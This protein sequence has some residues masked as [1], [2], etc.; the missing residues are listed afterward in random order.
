MSMARV[1]FRR[2]VIEVWYKLLNAGCRVPLVAGSGK[3]SNAQALG[4]RR[5]YARMDAFSYRNWIDAVR[6]GRVFVT[7]GP[8]VT[9]TVEGKG[10]GETVAVPASQPTIHVKV[11]AKSQTP[12]ERLELVHNGSALAGI[13]AEG[14][15]PTASF[16]VDLPVP[17]SGWLAGAVWQ[18]DAEE[19]VSA[20]TGPIYVEVEGKPFTLDVISIAF[21]IDHL[22]RMLDWV[23]K[24]A[25]F[26]TDKQR[27][28]LTGIFRSAR[29]E[30]ERRMAA[31]MG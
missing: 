9:L 5:T 16:E 29:K 15:P 17:T 8:I 10:P 26:A 11:E 22:D 28:D 18:P 6:A 19:P 1:G 20:H 3:V 2:A 4:C 30:L 12:F 27:E 14:Q 31:S 13:E 21:W 23:E 25:R 24:Q 7:R